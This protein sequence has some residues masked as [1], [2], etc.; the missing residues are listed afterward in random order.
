MLGT[1]GTLRPIFEGELRQKR[2]VRERAMALRK[3]VAE[4]GLDYKALKGEKNIIS[5]I[6][7]G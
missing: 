6:D 7:A 5:C 3:K 2:I 1:Q 4:S